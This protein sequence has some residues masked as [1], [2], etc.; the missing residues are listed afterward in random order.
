M[1]R[2]MR[3]LLVTAGTLA[4]FLA[5][6]AWQAPPA[7]DA[8]GRLPVLRAA[9]PR[10]YRGN[11]HTHS[12]WSDGDDF[13]EMIADWYRGHGYDFLGLSDHNVLSDGERWVPAAGKPAREA[14]VRKYLDRF[15]AAWVE[16]REVKGEGQ[17]R[18]KPLAEFRS[19]LEEPGKFLLIPAEEIT[20]AYQK[21][22]VHVNAVNLRDPIKP[23]VGPDVT[24]TI[25]VNHRQVAEQAKKT[26]RPMFAFLNHPNFGWGVRGEEMIEADELG[27]FEVFNGH[28]SVNNE[29]DTTHPDTDR[30]WDIALAVRLGRLGRGPVLALGTDDAHNYHARGFK[31]ANPGRGWVMVRAPYLTAEAIVAAMRRGDFYASSGVTLDD[32]TTADGELRLTI[33]GEPGV[34]YHTEFVATL[35]GARLDSTPRTDADGKPL[36]VTR[37]YDN[38]IGQ[39]V[40]TAT[41]LTPRYKL[42]GNELYVRARV[43][44]SK[45]HPNPYR[46]GQVEMAWTQPVVPAAR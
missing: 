37:V 18:L 28:P 22:P 36:P 12:L 45:P 27:F 29:G 30:L 4:T 9:G 34:T 6:I 14:A 10:W 1:L 38:A 31:Q 40:A 7:S 15:G 17:V 44:S 35:R 19:L 32:V 16:R 13:P 11:L 39:T 2:D 41:G 20:T 46:K 43:R 23:I 5:A 33:R 3:V 42:T 25:R 8:P 21:A 24:E 26:G